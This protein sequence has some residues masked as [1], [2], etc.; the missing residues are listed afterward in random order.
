VAD[1][2]LLDTHVWLWL[3]STPGRLPAD[4]LERLA[5][6]HRKLYLS[7]A[8]SWE[9]AV[10]YALGKLALPDPPA[11][12][13]PDRMLRSGTAGV[14]VE[15]GHALAVADLPQ[16]HRDPFDRMLIAQSRALGLRLITADPLIA[17]YDVD[18]ELIT[19]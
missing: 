5:D 3:Q 7:A 10:K 12:Y 2:F 14:A 17:Q 4:L 13:V 8:S 18:H 9:I 1:G 11:K 15:H 19:R 16:L 6:E